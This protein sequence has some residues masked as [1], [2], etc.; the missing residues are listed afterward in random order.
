MKKISFGLV[1]IFAAT[2]S[3][4]SAQQAMS[5]KQCIDYGLKN[6]LSVKV[7]TNDIEQSKQKA[8]EALADYLPQ[9][10]ING[11]LDR[12]LKVQ[13]NILSLSSADGSAIPGIP[14]GS[15]DMIIKLG[16]PYA[17]G[18]VGELNQ[19]IYNQAKLVGIKASEPNKQLSLLNKQQ[20]DENIIYNVASAYFQIIVLQKQL[21]LQQDDKNRYKK[22][23]S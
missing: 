14:S 10:S 12:N 18:F 4:S 11:N 2:F 19:E 5:L 6:H 16:T 1:M 7:Y 13:S 22:L 21:E 17:A 15:S 9:V 8:N 23:L 3:Q 20:N